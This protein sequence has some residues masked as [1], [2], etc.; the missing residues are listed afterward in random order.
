MPIWASEKCDDR[1]SYRSAPAGGWSKMSDEPLVRAPDAG[2]RGPL[3]RPAQNAERKYRRPQARPF[4][5]GLPRKVPCFQF[6][7]LLRSRPSG[8]CGPVLL[9]P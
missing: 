4:S 3:D 2:R 5:L 1:R 8:V 6:A 7:S 9:P